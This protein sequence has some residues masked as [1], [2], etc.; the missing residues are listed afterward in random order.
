MNNNTIDA[1]AITMRSTRSARCR[2]RPR[3][4]KIRLFCLGQVGFIRIQ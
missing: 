2:R 3:R 4:T 1:T